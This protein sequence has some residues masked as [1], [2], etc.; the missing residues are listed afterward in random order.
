MKIDRCP[1]CHRR[2][3]RS[4][5]ANRRYWALL[6][7]IADKLRPQGREYSAEQ[8]HVYMKSRFL[9]CQEVKLP[10]GKTMLLPNSSADLDVAAFAE[11]QEKVE[12][13]AAEHDVYLADLEES[14]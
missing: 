4:A 5:E 11:Y 6:H 13:W 7:V 3:V 9:G 1:T 2:M 12:A 8:F 10:N 14:K